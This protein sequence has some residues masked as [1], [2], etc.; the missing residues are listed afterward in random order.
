MALQFD[1]HSLNFIIILKDFIVIQWKYYFDSKEFY[2]HSLNYF[3]FQKF[4]C[5]SLIYYYY[6]EHP[7]QP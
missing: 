2:Y 5:Y 7:L 3:D 6:Y 1:N 4:C